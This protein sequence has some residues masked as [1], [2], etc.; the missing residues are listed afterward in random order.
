[1]SNNNNTNFIDK[2]LKTFSGTGISD[3]EVIHTFE[4][5][6]GLQ[7]ITGIRGDLLEIGV[8][9]RAVLLMII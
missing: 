6:L 1:M 4:Q 5:L 9:N 2:H 3:L 7:F 8:L